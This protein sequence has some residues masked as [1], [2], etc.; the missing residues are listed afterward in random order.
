MLFTIF[1]DWVFLMRSHKL[2]QFDLANFGQFSDLR[3]NLE[4][5][6]FSAVIFASSEIPTERLYFGKTAYYY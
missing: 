2:V 3:F 6:V 4:I 5:F 1:E